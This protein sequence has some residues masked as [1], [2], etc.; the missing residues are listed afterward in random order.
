MENAE[1]FGL[2]LLDEARK[3]LEKD[4]SFLP[5]AMIAYRDDQRDFMMI[6][7][8]IMNDEK[9][10]AGFF[11]MLRQK[12]VEGDALAVVFLSDTY[13]GT[14]TKAQMEKRQ[15]IEERLGIRMNVEQMHKIG[16]CDKRE[17]IL[18]TVQTRLD[19]VAISQ[20]YTRRMEGGKTVGVDFGPYSVRRDS[21]GAGLGGR[22]FNFFARS[23]PGVA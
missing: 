9:Q 3:D 13:V 22:A 18:L 7:P 8:A 19:Q 5:K 2:W 21:D 10:K 1:E 6:D 11:R 4:G 14:Q 23:A 20:E 17:A 16:L 12:A 15:F